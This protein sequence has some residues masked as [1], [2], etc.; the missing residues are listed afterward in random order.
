MSLEQATDES[1]PLFSLANK[2]Y[3]GKIV[4]VVDG[5]TCRVVVDIEQQLHKFTCRLY[6][7]DTA[8][9]KPKRDNPRREEIK[10]KAKEAKSRLEELSKEGVVDVECFEFDK[11]GRLLVRIHTSKGDCMNDILVGE[12]LAYIYG[13]VKKV[14][15]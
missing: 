3:K 7:I 12:G 1:V 2:K 11:Y 9:M 5:D 4:H 6:G 15:E 8:E 13:G 14:M 10:K